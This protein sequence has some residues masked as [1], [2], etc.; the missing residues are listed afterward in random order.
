MAIAGMDVGTSGCKILIYD[1]DGNIIYKTAAN[2]KELG[3]DGCREIDSEEIIVNIKYLLSDAAQNCPEPIEALAVASLGESVVCL[4]A[5]DKILSK[6]M[7]TGDKRGIDEAKQLI[8]ELGAEKILNITGLPPSE[9]YGLPKYMWMNKHTSAIKDAKS[10]F[11]YEDYVGYVLTGKRIVSYSSASRS[12]AFDINKKCWSEE[13]LSYAGIE[14]SQMSVPV[15]AGTVIGKILPDMAEKLGLDKEFIVVAGGH[16]Q[17]CAALGSGL[18]RPG[19]GECG[20]GTCEFIFMMLQNPELKQ[21]AAAKWNTSMSQ[22][23]IENDLP[24]VPYVLE[25]RYLTSLEVTTC[26]ILKNWCR[27]T[28]LKSAADECGQRGVNFFSYMDDKVK[29]LK[30]DLL[31]LPQFGSSGNPD[32]NYDVRGTITGLTIHTKPEELYLAVLEGLAFQMLLSYERAGQIGARIEKLICTGGGAKSDVTLQMRADVFDIEV[33]TVNTE[34]SGTLGCMILAAVGAGKFDSIQ[35]AIDKVVAV[36]KEYR[37]IKA[38]QQY[39]REK[40]QRFKRLYEA[41][42]LF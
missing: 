27:D 14:V 37:P 19:V 10:I 39:Y 26:G 3:E 6:S 22:Y 42:H 41:M 36:K 13:L 35:E 34:E 16:D 18:D 25:N 9:M 12:M 32:I 2:Y 33:A 7:V 28:L 21:K 15:Q 29:D 24:C 38:N 20:M 1:L 5:N 4:D 23:M 30:T 8:E 17:S 11:F 31:L 40:Y